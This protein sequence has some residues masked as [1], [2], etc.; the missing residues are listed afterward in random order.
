MDWDTNR[1]LVKRQ[2][3][4]TEVLKSTAD[5]N[6]KEGVN[7]GNTGKLHISGFDCSFTFNAHFGSKEEQSHPSCENREKTTTKTEKDPTRITTSEAGSARKELKLQSLKRLHTNRA[8]GS[9][10]PLKPQS[11]SFLFM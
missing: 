5:G 8:F 6:V 3:D 2:G 9:G 7:D 10:T 11:S 1:S 4:W